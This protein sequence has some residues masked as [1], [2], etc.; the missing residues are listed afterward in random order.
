MN[1]R[2]YMAELQKIDLLET[3]EESRLWYAYKNNN[4]E[5][6]RC[7]IIESYQPLVFKCVRQFI[8]AEFVMDLV[9]EGI[10]GLIEAVERYEPE[11]NIAFSLYAVHRIKGRIMNYLKKEYK[12]EQFVYS[13]I[14]TEEQEFIASD[15]NVSEQAEK[16]FLNNYIQKE[17]LR[18]PDK[19]RIVLDSVYLKDRPP[20]ELAQSLDISLAHVYRL[21]KKA[22]QRLRGMMSKF[23][24]NWH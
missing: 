2:D 3:E 13:D 12:G 16:N 21:Q 23:M 9:Q 18:L 6:A 22:V 11:K 1:I 8:K 15:I 14:L 4:D 7:Q 19:E 24:H 10:V 5:D 20:Q 17:M